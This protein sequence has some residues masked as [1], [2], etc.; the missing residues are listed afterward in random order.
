MTRLLQQFRE[1]MAWITHQLEQRHPEVLITKRDLSGV[2]HVEV[3]R[4]ILDI[5]QE[6]KYPTDHDE[7]MD[8]RMS[9]LLALERRLGLKGPYG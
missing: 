8:R 4:D 6:K 3:Y 5:L 9:F 1:D 2:A 7:I